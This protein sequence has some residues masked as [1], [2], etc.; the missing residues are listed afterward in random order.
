M[1]VKGCTDFQDPVAKFNLSS[2][3]FN[4]FLGSWKP[5]NV[6]RWRVE[7]FSPCCC[8]PSNQR[9]LA[10]ICVALQNPL[11]ASHWCNDKQ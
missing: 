6:D 7:S 8:S 9:D 2:A 3:G 10:L 4:L 1:S 5:V 11:P